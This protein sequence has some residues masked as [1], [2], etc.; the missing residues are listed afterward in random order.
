MFEGYFNLRQCFRK[1][2]YRSI[3]KGG[4]IGDRSQTITDLLLNLEDW[5]SI[6][7]AFASVTRAGEVALTRRKNNSYFIGEREIIISC[8]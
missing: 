5:T 4:C 2:L 8:S 3:V 1:R 7:L 6:S